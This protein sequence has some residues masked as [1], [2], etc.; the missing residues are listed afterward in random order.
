MCLTFFNALDPGAGPDDEDVW[1]VSA[2][3]AGREEKVMDEEGKW[4]K[5]IKGAPDNLR[6][7]IQWQFPI[8]LGSV[9]LV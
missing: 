5:V 8:L 1:I 9:V 7:A 3:D 4:A 2:F 6:Q